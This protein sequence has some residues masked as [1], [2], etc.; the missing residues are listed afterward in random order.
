MKVEGLTL[1]LATYR[2]TDFEAQS[3]FAGEC[4]YCGRVMND[5]TLVAWRGRRS[6]DVVLHRRC[7]LALGSHLIKDSFG[8]VGTWREDT[9]DSQADKIGW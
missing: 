1:P 9:Y 4:F 6:Q 7:A 2:K 8:S 5:E 3:Y